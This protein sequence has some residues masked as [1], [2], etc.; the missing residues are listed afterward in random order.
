MANRTRTPKLPI[1]ADAPTKFIP[2]VEQRFRTT[3]R[4]YSP[5]FKESFCADIVI[6]TAA[7]W[8]EF[9]ERAKC[10]WGVQLLDNGM[11]IAACVQ[12]EEKKNS[13]WNRADDR[14]EDVEEIAAL[15]HFRSRFLN[16]LEA[17][18]DI[19]RVELTNAGDA[20]CQFSVDFKDHDPGVLVDCYARER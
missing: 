16:F 10:T 6:M 14:I 18:P 2:V 9:S 13:I 1:P 5:D 11:V 3:F 4:W 17:S 19:F 15:R 7:E 20:A 8:L 12:A